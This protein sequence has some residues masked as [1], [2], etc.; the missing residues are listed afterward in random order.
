MATSDSIETNSAVDV[1]LTEEDI[2]AFFLSNSSEVKNS[3]LVANFR[4]ALKSGRHR[5]A[6]RQ[7]FPRFINQLATTRLDVD[8]RKIL[9]LKKKFRH[10][11][12]TAA[13]SDDD[14]DDVVNSDTATA[15][16]GVTD[17]ASQKHNNNDNHV[18]SSADDKEQTALQTADDEITGSK[19]DDTRQSDKDEHENVAEEQSKVEDDA[20][21]NSAD[22]DRKDE[23]TNDE[24]RI[25]QRDDK[26]T[27]TESEN[28]EETQPVDEDTV[29]GDNVFDG[30]PEVPSAPRRRSRKKKGEKLSLEGKSSANSSI[31]ETQLP[32]DETTITGVDDEVDGGF[33]ALFARR[34]KPQTTERKSSEVIV[35]IDQSFVDQTHAEK[36][37]ADDDHQ[38]F[39]R[40][41]ELAQ[42]IDETASKRT[43]TAAVMRTKKQVSSVRATA[44]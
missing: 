15:G 8:G 7:R 19:E 13:T 42:R 34:T 30:G 29:T 28:V 24:E 5:T 37:S 1:L 40:V 33:K 36:Q 35:V 20:S 2:L 3:E 21:K 22:V 14:N 26:S 41:R 39:R 32:N 43:S 38:D 17:E 16:D 12:D 44:L 6:N 4:Q 18:Y 11:E 9:T 25:A 31:E 10:P 23:S 27:T